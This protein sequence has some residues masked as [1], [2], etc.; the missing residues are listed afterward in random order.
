M[1][2]FGMNFLKKINLEFPA[3]L[4]RSN[5]EQRKHCKLNMLLHLFKIGHRLTYQNIYLKDVLY[6]ELILNYFA[7]ISYLNYYI[8]RK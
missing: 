7:R 2:R 6:G 3:L 4:S 1:F 5:L 8:F